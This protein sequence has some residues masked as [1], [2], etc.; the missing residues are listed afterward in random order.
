MAI[1]DRLIQFIL[2]GKDELSPE[3]KKVAD[4][5]SKVSEEGKELTKALDSAKDAQGLARTFRSTGEEAARIRATLERT[6]KRAAEL[7]EELDRAP[8]SKGLATSLREAERDAAKAGREL[9]RLT[10]QTKEAEAAAQ[11]AGD[12]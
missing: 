12:R 5:L 7:R 4:A 10:V 6:N 8:G 3:A 11:A 2:R 9:D 1:K